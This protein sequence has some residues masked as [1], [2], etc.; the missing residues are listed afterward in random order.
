VR[1]FKSRE[2]FFWGTR[3]GKGPRQ[4][5]LLAQVCD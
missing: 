3:F 1:F 4:G 5:S 2:I